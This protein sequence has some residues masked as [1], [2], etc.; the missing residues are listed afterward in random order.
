MN[1][2]LQGLNT[3][4]HSAPLLAFF[5]VF[6]GGILTSFEPCIYVMLPITVAVIGSQSEGKKLKS[7]LMSVVYVSGI[8]VTY[9][10]LGAIAALTGSIFGSMSTKPIVNF[11]MGNICILLGLSMFDIFHIKIPSFISN[12][13][14][15][16][17][18][19]GFTMIFFLGIFSGLVAGP[20]TAAVLGVTL[21]YVAT[22]QN[23]FFGISLL[24]TFSIG[25]GILL[26]IIGTFTGILTS[27]PK[28]GPWMEKIRKI[29]GIILI[30]IGEYF[31]YITGKF[32]I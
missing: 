6:I 8:S 26:I 10:A 13:Q 5:A 4:L 22:K 23:L 7:F 15:K 20:C 24:F 14:G 11:I 30:C 9:S 28:A 12:L 19:K 2:F 32:S 21:A 16:R 17:I 31:L 27:I 29:L 18:G 25:M 3:Y 1:E